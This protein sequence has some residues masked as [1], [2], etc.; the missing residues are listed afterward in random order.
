MR[1][2]I[3]AGMNKTGS[4]SIQRTLEGMRD[5]NFEYVEWVSSNHSEMYV[6]LFQEEALLE[7]YHIFQTQGVRLDEL[8]KRRRTWRARL[9]DQLA[10]TDK[11]LVV[12]SGE[13]I[14]Q[15]ARNEVA[16]T[17]M[18]DY[19]ARHFDDIRI[20]A[21]VRPPQS[22][23][24]SAFQQKVK[25]A[26]VDRI[27]VRRLWP[28]YRQ[29]FERLDRAFGRE[30]VTL[31]KFDRENLREGDVVEDF[32]ARSAITGERAAMRRI[33]DSLSLEAL[34]LLFAH[35]RLAGG[36]KKGFA[37]ATRQNNAMVHQLSSI[38]GRK[39]ELSAGL[40]ADAIAANADDLAWM[41]ER[42]ETTLAEELV[43]RDG[44]IGSEDDLL[45]VAGEAMGDL[46]TLLGALAQR[47]AIPRER[48]L[49]A[50]LGC[51]EEMM[52]R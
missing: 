44:Q 22:F 5:T 11:D 19:F 33:N 2:I 15:P 39:F 31:V 21:Y 38:K 48:R 32:I 18:Q 9:G 24:N 7:R 6:L 42:L 3:H 49:S 45:E 26:G 36:M 12:F 30:N 40:I 1:L 35:R 37:S 10:R 34:A 16:V 47:R 23:I 50:L 43:E 25:S 51:M 14:S 8:A 17:A 20:I 4:S 29:R 52:R 46:A 28:N 41:E 13:D 27:D